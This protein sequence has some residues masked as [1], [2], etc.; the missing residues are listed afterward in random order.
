GKDFQRAEISTVP[1]TILILIIAFGAAVAA[2]LPVLL[3]FS[4]VLA[5]IGLAGLASHVFPMAGD[6]K[7]VILLVG[8]AVG[9]D[10]SLFYIRREREERARGCSRHE[11]IVRTAATSGHTVLIS[12]L[13]VLIAMSGMFFSG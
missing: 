1:L 9:I 7:S 12:G 10:Y 4:G 5:T 3:A 8:M 2:G 13:T 11:A 6:A